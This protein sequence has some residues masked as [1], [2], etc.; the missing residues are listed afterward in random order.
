MRR[1]PPIAN[2]KP[3]ASVPA[4]T[5][6]V[7]IIDSEAVQPSGP[8]CPNCGGPVESSDKFCPACG[9]G[10]RAYAPMPASPNA[11]KHSRE[12][13]EATFAAPTKHFRCEQCGA[14]V[15]VDPQQRSYVCPFCDSTYVV[16]FD[17]DETS[18]Q[19]P[20]FII[21]FTI[22]P[23]Q[24]RAKFR[25]WIGR[26]Q[27]FNPSDLPIAAVEEKQRGVYLPFW[28][29]PMLAES[30]WSARIGEHW[31][32][33][34]T[35]TTHH[36]GKLVTR[37]RTVTETEWWPLAGRHHKFYTGYLVSGS[38]GLPQSEALRIMPFNL[39]ALKRYE[40]Y[41]LAGWLCEEYSVDQLSGLRL[42]QQEYHEQERRNIQAFLPGDTSSHLEVSTEFSNISCDLCL[43]PIYLLSYRYQNQLYR[44]LVNGQTGK[45]AGDKPVSWQRIS[46]AVGLGVAGVAILIGLAMWVAAM[47]G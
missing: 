39:P 27:W 9:S 33:R 6:E 25:A 30:D 13:V 2:A 23:E 4:A 10:N 29:F 16:E 37:T 22:T 1:L 28:S 19:Q 24:A 20:E 8:P 15:L 31:Q 45:V 44:F 40:P 38:K 34:E 35:Y 43:L 5:A 47:A 32:R 42:C 21:G 3:R 36:N 46:L 17:R 14:E 7:E 11:A 41:Y 26:N 18:R 12:V